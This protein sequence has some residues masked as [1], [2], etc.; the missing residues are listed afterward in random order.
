MFDINSFMARKRLKQRY[1]AKMLGCSMGIVASWCV[2][3]KLPSYK[4]I[5]AFIR[6]GMTM[7]EL[8]G[9]EIADLISQNANSSLLNKEDFKSG[10]KEMLE[11][12]LKEK[13]SG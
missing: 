9:A 6:N 8:F 11:E 7:T 1:V 12:I 10:M 3:R 5:I 2:G 13:F 4:Y